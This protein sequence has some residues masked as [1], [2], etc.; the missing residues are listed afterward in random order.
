MERVAFFDGLPL[1]FAILRRPSSWLAFWRSGAAR[2]WR[3]LA[4][5]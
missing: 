2:G 1:L 5:G 4:G 3:A